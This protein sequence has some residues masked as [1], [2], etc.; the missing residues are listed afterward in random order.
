MD[1]K[2]LSIGRTLV[3]NP[4]WVELVESWEE[5]K[6]LQILNLIQWKIKESRKIDSSF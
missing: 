4:D 3:I 6:Q 1:F 2:I 5:E